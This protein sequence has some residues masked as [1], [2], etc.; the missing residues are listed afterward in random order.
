MGF[1]ILNKEGNAQ[2]INDL[3]KQI[4]ELWQVPVNK[5]SYAM[6]NPRSYYKEGIKGQMNYLRQTNWFDGIGYTIHSK[7]CESWNEVKS[8]LHKLYSDILLKHHMTL[9]QLI[10]KTM[11]LISYWEMLGYTPRHCD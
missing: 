1:Q 7:Q 10:P 2:V 11:L 3:D 4:C 6:P 8:E 9:K 5:K